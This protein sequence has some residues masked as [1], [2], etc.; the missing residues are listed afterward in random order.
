MQPHK[1]V[2]IQIFPYP[3]MRSAFGKHQQFPDPTI[4]KKSR[5]LYGGC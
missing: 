1:S 2:Q 4:M 3:E 5:L